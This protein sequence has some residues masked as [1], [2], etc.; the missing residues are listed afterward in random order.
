[1]KCNVLTDI[2]IICIKTY[3]LDPSHYYTAP[4]LIGCYVKKFSDSL[5]Y[6]IHANDLYND[7]KGGLY[8]YFDTSNYKILG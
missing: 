1:M 5:I 8:N 7:I 6:N 2:F 4:G 3:D